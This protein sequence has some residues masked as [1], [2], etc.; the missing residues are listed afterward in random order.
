[1]MIWSLAG[2]TCGDLPRQRPSSCEWTA[3]GESHAWTSRSR[4]RRIL[5]NWLTLTKSGALAPTPPPPSA[6]RSLLAGRTTY[7]RRWRGATDGE[8]LRAPRPPTLAVRLSPPPGVLGITAV[9]C[10][11]SL[12]PRLTP[13]EELYHYLRQVTLAAIANKKCN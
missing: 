8:P 1:M 3:A 6:A 11:V 4:Q 2:W 10:V 7:A 13:L 12:M 5:P 9:S